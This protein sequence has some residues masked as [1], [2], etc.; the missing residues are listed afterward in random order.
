METKNI[1]AYGT[2][3]ANA[4]LTHIATLNLSNVKS[5]A[6]FVKKRHF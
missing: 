1:K 2:P 3:A 6:E 4:P 5:G